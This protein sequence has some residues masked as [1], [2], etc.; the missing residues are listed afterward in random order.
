MKV[1]NDIAERGMKLIEDNNKI[2]TNDEQQKQYL[3]Q[4][5]SNYRKKLPDKTKK[6]LISLTKQ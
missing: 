2:I 3:L 1:V 4:V 6:T 5:V